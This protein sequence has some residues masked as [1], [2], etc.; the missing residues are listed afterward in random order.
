MKTLVAAL[1]RDCSDARLPVAI[2]QLSRVVGEV[3]TSHWDSIR[4]LQRKLAEMIPHLA[5]VPAVDAT[6]SDPIHIDGRS[7]V[8]V[9]ER[10]ADAMLHL[11]GDREHGRAPMALKSWRLDKGNQVIVEFDHVAGRLR[12][13][14][15][16]MGFD[17]FNRAGINVG[18][19]TILD[20]NR[21]VIHCSPMWCDTDGATVSYAHGLNPCC[22]VEDES[23][24][25]VP[26][27]GPVLLG[28]PRYLTPFIRA[29][30]VSEC[31]RLKGTIRNL[32]YPGKGLAMTE[33]SFGG[34]MCTIVCPFG[35]FAAGGS[36]VYASFNLKT[37]AFMRLALH[38]G[39][40]GPVKVWVNRREVFC[41][42]KGAMPC[43]PDDARV[44]FA[45]RAGTHEV[46]IA[47]AANPNETWGVFLRVERVA[48]FDPNRAPPSL[49][50]VV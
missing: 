48:P 21:V 14:S 12:A 9:G 2:V 24:W 11:T 46:M 44:P 43:S 16:P 25:P 1:R 35:Q 26:A 40:D 18:F 17:V 8:S 13:G 50:S 7:A 27:F 5:C 32:P 23:G 38:L 4:D 34:E 42:P 6:F 37:P 33:E 29:L 31:G 36:L 28:P 15:R 20:G 45:V 3:E 47:L 39:Y 19:D 41:D 30:R 49:P 22:N 10:L